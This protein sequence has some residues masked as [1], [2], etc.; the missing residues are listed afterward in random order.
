MSFRIDYFKYFR[1][2]IYLVK[3]IERKPITQLRLFIFNFGR[4]MN[5]FYRIF[6]IVFITFIVSLAGEAR[7]C[8]SCLFKIKSLEEPFSLTGKWLF[9]REDKISNKDPNTSTDSWKV[10]KAPGP[11]G[12]AY[13]NNKDFDI[14]WYRGN[15]EF[16]DKLLGTKAV[17][18]VDSYMGEMDVYL[19]GKRIYKRKGINVY[20]KFYAIQAIPIQFDITKKKHTISFRIKNFL[21]TGVYQLPFQIRKFEKKDKIVALVQFYGGELRGFLALFF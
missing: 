4:N 2:L 1:K 6:S 17:F 9:T 5:R 8:D 12:K 16:S 19:D 15:F 18:L 14:G 7:D 20:E 3:L 10:I 11:W 13:K 21:M